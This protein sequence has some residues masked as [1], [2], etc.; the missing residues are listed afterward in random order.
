LLSLPALVSRNAGSAAESPS[1]SSKSSMARNNAMQKAPPRKRGKRGVEEATEGGSPLRKSKR[2]RTAPTSDLPSPA[3]TANANETIPDEDIDKVNGAT[4]VG[5]DTGKAQRGIR[6]K[7]RRVVAEVAEKVEVSASV[8]SDKRE[9]STRKKASYV[10][11]DIDSDIDE[12]VKEEEE[13][14]EIVIKSKVKRTKKTKKTKE[15]K[16]SE[17]MPLAARAQGLRMF[18]GAHVSAA[19][20]QFFCDRYKLSSGLYHDVHKLNYISIGVQNSVTNSVHIG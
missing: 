4:P 19:K 2:S 20:G 14:K 12:E 13:E 5:D 17:A 11:Q 18:V 3:P 16:E 9:R 7:K 15:E 6:H 10:D 8:K 1:P